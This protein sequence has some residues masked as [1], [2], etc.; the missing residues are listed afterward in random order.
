MANS[1]EEQV[2]KINESDLSLS[3]ESGLFLPIQKESQPSE[4]NSIVFSDESRYELSG[5]S[6]NC[7]EVKDPLDSIFYSVMPSKDNTIIRFYTKPLFNNIVS[8][9]DKEFKVPENKSTKFSVKT[10]IDGKKCNIHV[11]WSDLTI[12][13][14]GPGHVFWRENNFRKLTINMFNNFV[15]MTNSALNVSHGSQP[16]GISESSEKKDSTISVSQA[17]NVPLVTDLSCDSP[18]MRNISTLMDMIHTLQKQVSTLTD[19]V[20]KLVQQA[21]ES[22]YQTVDVIHEAPSVEEVFSQADNQDSIR[23]DTSVTANLQESLSSPTIIDITPTSDRQNVSTADL[24]TSTPRP[25]KPLPP[26]RKPS[27]PAPSQQPAQRLLP[28]PTPRQSLR[29]QPRQTLLIG[30]SIVS[31]INPKG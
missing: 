14:T 23:I 2:S 4:S 12:S 19:Q 28:V 1:Q 17:D 3:Q 11:G 9:L 27:R 6:A 7:S 5:F 18:V 13:L 25:N 22:V 15:D 24:Q 29:P 20:N 21:S 30:D 16:I 31:G 10:H 8:V 26:T